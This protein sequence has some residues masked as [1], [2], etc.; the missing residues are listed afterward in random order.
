MIRRYRTTR[1]SRERVSELSPLSF[2]PS[3]SLDT[4]LIYVDPREEGPSFLGFGGALTR[5]SQELLHEMDEGTRKEALSLLFGKEGLNYSLLRLTISS[6]DFGSSCYDYLGGGHDLSSFSFEEEEKSLLPLLREIAPMRSDWIRMASSWAPPAYMKENGDRCYGGHLRKE[7]Y[8]DYG[9]YL[10]LYLDSMRKNGFPI[11]WMS[12]QNEPEAIQLWESMEVTAE[13][14]GEII[15]KGILPA[16]RR[17]GLD[18]KIII[19]D[20]NKDE[21][22]RRANVTLSRK[23]VDEAVWGIGYHWYVS[24]NFGNV[25]LAK[26]LHPGKHLIFTEGCVELANIAYGAEGTGSPDLWEHAWRYG[27]NIIECLRRGTEAYIDWNLVLDEKGTPP[28]TTYRSSPGS[29]KEGPGCALARATSRK[30]W[31]PSPSRTPGERSSSSSSTADGTSPRPSS[32]AGRRRS[33]PFLPIP[34]PRSSSKRKEFDHDEAIPATSPGA[35]L[36]G[37][38]HGG[39]H[40]PTH[41]E[42]R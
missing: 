32:S 28:I 12:V 24:H 13:E 29:S 40:P 16:L 38:A 6:T 9:E 39:F 3:L 33:S 7:C 5:A 20:H 41:G 18:T 17:H 37:P 26:R 42:G 1:R 15:L 36:G 8:G 10:A 31:T 2:D 14:E 11:D 34:S 4:R 19:W 21:M 25:E 27:K 35:C 22:V 23:E 30:A